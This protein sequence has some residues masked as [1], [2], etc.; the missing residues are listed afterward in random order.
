MMGEHQTFSINPRT[1]VQ[2]G[3]AV[4]LTREFLSRHGSGLDDLLGRFHGIEGYS[5]R[6]AV[7][8][9]CAPSSTTMELSLALEEVVDRLL[10]LQDEAC[11]PQPV[12]EGRRLHVDAGLRW[13]AARFHDLAR[14][15]RLM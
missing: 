3:T 14:A 6:A 11:H 9:S 2:F 5:I 10:S 15:A 1:G 4:R 7:E 13:Y 12:D 8:A